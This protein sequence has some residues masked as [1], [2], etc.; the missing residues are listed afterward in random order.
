LA[1][2]HFAAADSDSDAVAGFHHNWQFQLGLSLLPLDK[3]FVP[4]TKHVPLSLMAR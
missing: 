2:A 4:M 3:D 1:F